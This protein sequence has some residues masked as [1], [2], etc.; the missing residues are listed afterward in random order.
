MS[1]ELVSSLFALWLSIIER[2][3]PIVS[4]TRTEN[5]ADGEKATEQ[6]STKHITERRET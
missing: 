5:G 6:H 3:K 4:Y 2:L 1:E